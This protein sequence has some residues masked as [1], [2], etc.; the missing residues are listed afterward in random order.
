M[1]QISLI[2]NPFSASASMPLTLA[3]DSALNFNRIVELS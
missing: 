2:L 1:I 3:G